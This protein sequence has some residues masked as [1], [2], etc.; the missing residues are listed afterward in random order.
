MAI[1][2]IVGGH[3]FTRTHVGHGYKEY[4]RRVQG[5]SITLRLRRSGPSMVAYQCDHFVQAA[6]AAT[7]EDV[8]LFLSECSAEHAALDARRARVTR[9]ARKGGGMARA[10][11]AC[12]GYVVGVAVGAL[13]AAGEAAKKA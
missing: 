11:W 1:I 5:A 4:T 13:A 9:K 6:S 7:H 8:A 2:K 10:A 3:K 12:V